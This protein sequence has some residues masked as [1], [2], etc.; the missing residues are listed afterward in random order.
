PPDRTKNNKLSYAYSGAVGYPNASS[1]TLSLHTSA[2]TLTLNSH[3]ANILDIPMANNTD[4]NKMGTETTGGPVSTNNKT[5]TIIRKNNII[6]E[7][8]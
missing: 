3:S 6:M 4:T 5:K 7:V 1:G 8:T 2:H